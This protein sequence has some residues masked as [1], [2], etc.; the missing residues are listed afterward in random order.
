VSSADCRAQ[1]LISLGM[2]VFNGERYIRA[3]LDDAL[4]Q[5]WGELEI[6]VS[7]NASTD[8]TR[9]I[10]E[11]YAARDSRIRYIRQERNRGAAWNYNE[12]FRR[13]R[14]D[15]FRWAPADDGMAP[16]HLAA[17][18]GEL[19]AHPY[20]V[21][22]YP[23][24]TLID[25]EGQPFRDYSDGL[26]LV[27]GRT[28][29]RAAAFVRRVNLCNAVLGLYRREQLARTRLIGPYPGSDAAL[30]FETALLGTIREVP[31]ALFRRRVHPEASHEA[32]PSPAARAAWF[33]PEGSHRLRLSPRLRLL[34]EYERVVWTRASVA[35]G[36]R[37]LASLAVLG[38]WSYRR[39][40][41][42]L[43][44][45]RQQLRGEDATTGGR[46]SGLD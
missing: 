14:G 28:W 31:R 36:E 34:L 41:A 5:S 18:L 23:R 43:G 19:Q 27:D 4:A 40:R 39:T 33:D 3:A 10:V 35:P 45:W 1:P 9:E 44:L 20:C 17:C 37:L 8:G 29:R 2:P 22:A 6:I 13:S 21:L 24:T 7:D 12:V 32:N 15:Y 26:H 16:D 11:D 42:R 25:A 46:W 30:L 38:V